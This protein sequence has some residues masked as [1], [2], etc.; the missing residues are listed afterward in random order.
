[1]RDMESIIEKNEEIIEN[2]YILNVRVKGRIPKITPGQFFMVRIEDREVFLRR[3]FTVYDQRGDLLSIMYKVRGRGTMVLS[4]MKKGQ[5]LSILGPLGRG[6]HIGKRDFYLVIA[7][8]IGIAGVHL[9]MKRIGKKAKLFYGTSSSLGVSLV[10][11]L[12]DYE[13]V[14]STMDGSYGYRG[15]VVSSLREKIDGFLGKDLEVFAC[16][17][18]EMYRSLKELL[19]KYGFACQILWEERMGCG[20]GLCF[21]CVVKTNDESDPEKRVCFEGPAFSL[22]EISL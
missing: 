10:K 18:K 6:F 7:G 3:P 13:P 21:G 9:L 2:H 19:S 20:M 17:P 12:M 22:W 8:G 16:G 1:M 11:D 4:R 5:K 14:I 15:D